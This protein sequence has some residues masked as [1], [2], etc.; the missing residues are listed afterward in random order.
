MMSHWFGVS[1]HILLSLA[2][3]KLL[4]RGNF[5]LQSPWGYL[6]LSSGS[7]SKESVCK[8]GNLYMIPG[9]RRSPR[10]GNSNP[11]QYSCL[12]H[13][14]G[15]EAWW[16]H[17]VAKSWTW[18]S[19][20]YTHKYVESSKNNINEFIYK[21]ETDPQ[22]YKNQLMVTKGKRIWSNKLEKY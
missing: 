7:D 11:L 20:K 5:E 6:G 4:N 16:I 22:T 8:A 1:P 3:W 14:V 21:A 18:L 12:E 15:R 19:D 13:S 17:G 10:E 2:T 9:S